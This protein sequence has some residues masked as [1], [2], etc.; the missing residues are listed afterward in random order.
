ML[1]LFSLL[2][3]SSTFK[4]DK[5]VIYWRGDEIFAGNISATDV[6]NRGFTEALIKDE[7]QP[8]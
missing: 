2:F 1:V 6:R 3:S 7:N 5:R 8:F 4:P